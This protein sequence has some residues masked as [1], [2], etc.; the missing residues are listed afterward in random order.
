[1]VSKRSE[2]VTLAGERDY[3][4]KVDSEDSNWMGVM[5]IDEG[6]MAGNTEVI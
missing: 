6:V 1:M 4:C 5:D 2:R 3:A